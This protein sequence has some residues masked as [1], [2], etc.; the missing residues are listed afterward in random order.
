MELSK[1]ELEILSQIASGNKAISTVALTLKKSKKQVYTAIKQ[2]RRKQF[3]SLVRGTIHPEHYLHTTLLLQTLGDYSYLVSMLSDSG[4]PILQLLATPRTV[5][6]IQEKTEYQKSV[7][8]QKLKRGIS[9][10]IV[11]KKEGPYQL[12]P[13]LWPVLKRFLYEVSDL[14]QTTDFRVPSSSVIYH[15]TTHE[16]VFS[17]REELDATLTAFSAYGNFGI[18]IYNI[19]HFYYLPKKELTVED[20]FRHS[21]YISE[22]KP[23]EIRYYIFIA[24]FYLKH[25]KKLGKIQHPI[26]EKLQ[27]TLRGEKLGGFPS[28]QEIKDRAAVYDLEVKP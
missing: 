11:T 17:T 28:L 9:H 26:L 12:N 20:V 25:R 16:I 18:T 2:L 19:T 5:K 27:Q 3:V 13:K 21:L 15:K 23:E 24:L 10:N 4:I 1:T 22:K 7:I 14:E 6:E 8:Y